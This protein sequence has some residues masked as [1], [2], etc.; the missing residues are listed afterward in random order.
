MSTETAE[1]TVREDWE[2]DGTRGML[3]RI[4]RPDL[5]NPI[6]HDTVKSLLHHLDD[7]ELRVLHEEA[8]G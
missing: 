7:A 2:V 5:R 6:D 4:N 3:I 8:T 1:V